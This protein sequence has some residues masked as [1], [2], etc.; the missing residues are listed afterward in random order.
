[1]G[2]IATQYVYYL[3][4]FNIKVSLPWQAFYRQ[5]K[6]LQG[7]LCLSIHLA[8]LLLIHLPGPFQPH[9]PVTRL[10]GLGVSMPDLLTPQRYEMMG[11]YNHLLITLIFSIDMCEAI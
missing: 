9:F 3:Y 2:Q 5:A 7:V 6:D 8:W 1:M 4:P 11:K 10:T